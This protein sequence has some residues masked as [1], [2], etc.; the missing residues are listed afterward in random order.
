MSART[1]RALVLAAIGCLGIA[2]QLVILR[3]LV[4]AFSG[5]EFSIALMLGSWIACEAAGALAFGRLARSRNP[6]QWLGLLALVSAAVS[7]AAVPAAILSRP[8]IGAL[9]GETLSI[10]ALCLI[11]LVIVSLPA[12]THGALFVTGAGLLASDGSRFSVPGRA[13]LW[14]GIGTAIAA[15]AISLGLA[16]HLPSLSL[17]ALAAI[18]LAAAM[19]LPGLGLHRMERVG[20]LLALLGIPLLASGPAGRVERLVWQHHW[21]GQSVFGISN[22]PYGKVIR[23]A[24]AGQ[25][26]VIFAGV[27]VMTSPAIDIARVEQIVGLPLLMHP[28]PQRVLIVGQ[29]LGGPAA[30]ALRHGVAQLVTTEPDAVLAR[31]LAAAGNSIVS[32]ELSNPRHVPLALD[33]RRLLA[34]DTCRFDVIVVL[35]AAPL[36]LSANRL[37]SLEAFRLCRRRLNPGGILCL[38]APGS[39]DRLRLAPDVERLVA[40]RQTT[41]TQAF[42]HVLPLAADVP[43]LLASDLP[44]AAQPET[45]ACRLVSRRAAGQVLDSAYLVALLDDFRQ[46]EFAR[47]LSQAD[48]VSWPN[49]DLHPREVA[50]SLVRENRTTSRFLARL[51]DATAGLRPLHLLAGLGLLLAFGLAGACSIGRRFSTGMAIASSGFCGAG[52]SMLLLFAYQARFGTLYTQ[53]ALLIGAFMLGSVLG[54]AAV[55]PTSVSRRLPVLFAADLL[56]AGLCGGVAIAP[57]TSPAWAFVLAQLAAGILLGAQFAAAGA[58]SSS[59]P[60]TRAGLLAGLD[61]VGGALGMLVCGLVLAPALGFVLAALALAGIKAASALGIVLSRPAPD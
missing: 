32:A 13:Y 57:L 36:S 16:T 38:N 30:T 33:P 54:A 51:Y 2:A 44:L 55:T 59:P 3:E 49:T 29:A 53:A 7:A 48:P 22:S 24:R 21:P 60:A 17:V 4:T 46:R 37:F 31:E 6:A 41:L 5:N 52:L 15:S 35:P 61:L 26:Q 39:A 58:S 45:L 56:L 20:A 50:L 23:I 28:N 8:I 42:T 43:L 1:P 19:L 12:L 18:P 40:L 9:P 27:P 34:V 47:S 14:E 25:Q 11:T 10:P